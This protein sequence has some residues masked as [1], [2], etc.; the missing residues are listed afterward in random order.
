MST[1]KVEED[2]IVP[3]IDARRDFVYAGIYNGHLFPIMNDMYISIEELKTKLQGKSHKFIS[4]DQ[5]ENIQAELP[6]IDVL[7]IIEK[8]KNDIGLNPNAINPNYLKL[9]EAEMKLNK[10]D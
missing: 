4:Y 7:R 8:H 9:T 5:F 10:N 3:V 2:Y 6:E 1:S